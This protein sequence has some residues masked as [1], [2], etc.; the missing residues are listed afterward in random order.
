[1]PVSDSWRGF[2]QTF[3]ITSD[4]NDRSIKL[5]NKA[6]VDV[7]TK[8]GFVLKLVDPVRRTIPVVKIDGLLVREDQF[9]YVVNICACSQPASLKQKVMV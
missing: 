5:L 2:R 7:A 6:L 9:L 1:M 3:T 4:S 8:A